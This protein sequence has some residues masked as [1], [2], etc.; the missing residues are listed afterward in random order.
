MANKIQ[1]A[2]VVVVVEFSSAAV[3]A[4]SNSMSGDVIFTSCVDAVV[5]VSSGAALSADSF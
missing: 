1:L 3:T 5:C 2:V 4:S